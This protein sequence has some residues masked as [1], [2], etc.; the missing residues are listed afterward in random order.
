MERQI[1]K[2]RTMGTGY[3][4]QESDRKLRI[5]FSGQVLV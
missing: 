4:I 1:R 5:K 3:R 2:S